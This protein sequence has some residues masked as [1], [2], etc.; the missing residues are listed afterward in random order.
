MFKCT[1]INTSYLLLPKSVS[2]GA[3]IRSLPP[4]N[5]PKQHLVKKPSQD[6]SQELIGTISTTG[7]INP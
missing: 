4:C 6:T 7:S 2:S 5:W 3:R 1:A